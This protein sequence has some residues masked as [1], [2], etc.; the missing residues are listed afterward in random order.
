M[1]TEIK[2]LDALLGNESIQ[3]GSIIVIKGGPGSGKTTLGLQILNNNLKAYRENGGEEINAGFISLEV[4]FKKAIDYARS[5]Y[6]FY[7]LML[8]KE[9]FYYASKDDIKISIESIFEKSHPVDLSKPFKECLKKGNKNLTRGKINILFVDSLNILIDLI[10]TI[11]TNKATPNNQSITEFSFREIINLICGTAMSGLTNKSKPDTVYIF[12]VEYH[13]SLL[14]NKIFISES[15]ISDIEILLSIEPIKETTLKPKS[16]ISGV[17]YEIEVDKEGKKAYEYRSFLR[18][19]K[20]RYSKHHSRRCSYDI[21]SGRGIVFFDTY[22]GDGQISL[23]Y[24]NEK[25]REVWQEFFLDDI[26]HLYPSL[27][28]EDFK[29]KNI[30]QTLS[31]HRHIKYI[32]EK[33]DLSLTSLDNYWVTWYTDLWRKSTIRDIIESSYVFKRYLRTLKMEPLDLCLDLIIN[34]IHS[35]LTRPRVDI[36]NYTKLFSNFKD[37]AMKGLFID[38]APK[39]NFSLHFSNRTIGYKKYN[40]DKT[41]PEN[42]AIYCITGVT[43]IHFMGLGGGYKRISIEG[44]REINIIGN[45]RGMIIQ[46]ISINGKIL[47]TICTN[48]SHLQFKVENKQTLIFNIQNGITY[49]KV[50]EPDENGPFNEI[51]SE[52]AGK[53]IYAIID[54][55]IKTNKREYLPCFKDIIL[56]FISSTYRKKINDLFF[57]L[58]SEGNLKCVECHFLT[59]LLSFFMENNKNI[60]QNL[61]GIITEIFYDKS[62]ALNSKEKIFNALK[63]SKMRID[64]TTECKEET[65]QKEIIY[66]L[67]REL[68][69]DKYLNCRYEKLP[70]SLAEMQESLADLIANRTI[71]KKA[72]CRW[73]IRFDKLLESFKWEID[74]NDLEKQLQKDFFDLKV[75]DGGHFIDK[76]SN[77]F[78]LKDPVL[79][80]TL[81]RKQIKPV[82][83]DNQILF[84][85]NLAVYFFLH[86][87]HEQNAKNVLCA[88]KKSELRL[89]GERNSDIIDELKQYDFESN[90]PVHHQDFVF[91]MRNFDEFISVPYD[92]NISFVVYNKTTLDIF[93]QVLVHKLKSSNKGAQENET[94]NAA[95]LKY[96]DLVSEIFT[97]KRTVLDSIVENPPSIIDESRLK[98]NLRKIINRS[99]LFKHPFT[100]EEVIALNQ[101][102]KCKEFKELYQDYKNEKTNNNKNVPFNEDTVFE[103]SQ[104]QPAFLIETQTYDTYLSILL[105]FIW[106]SGGD[107]CSTPDY[108]L[109]TLRETDNLEKNEAKFRKDLLEALYLICL[110]FYS[111]TIPENSTLEPEMFMNRYSEN[112]IAPKNDLGNSKDPIKKPWLFARHWYSTFID[113][114]AAKSKDPSASKGANVEQRELLWK[115]IAHQLGIMPIPVSIDRYLKN[116]DHPMEVKHISCWGDWHFAILRGSENEALGV[117]LINKLMSSRNIADRAEKCAHVP[118]TEAFYSMYGKNRCINIPERTDGEKLPNITYNE[119][120]NT[121]FKHAKSRSQIFDFHHYMREI[122]A[123]LKYAEH[124]SI[125]DKAG[126]TT[127]PITE[128]PKYLLRD[129]DHKIIEAL[130]VMREFN[131]QGLNRF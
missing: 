126:S 56:K 91:S 51:N 94:E 29:R 84:R 78:E 26:P 17:G 37:D 88:Q 12:S 74:K 119:L 109:S 19:I 72:N 47:K 35:L 122:H 102:I 67:L 57:T 99:L 82:D 14:E 130:S 85:K 118:T 16:F 38:Y 59:N 18:V 44:S 113:L 114:L 60:K 71:L 40:E 7:E 28:Y 106:N 110:M 9:N 11:K 31:T 48:H 76:L 27:R 97:K 128:F 66:D 125:R 68:L 45:T 1:K 65:L 115:G 98:N 24:E 10:H 129:I 63:E 116:I 81:K 112:F 79:V 69:N 25:Q 103:W 107:I 52:I 53:S 105:E 83:F 58:S 127:E 22:P 90:R 49:K 95:Y 101:V 5:L 46:R 70:S 39:N 23:F 3:P 4:P 92:A 111:G 6:G 50:D 42:P 104:P 41:L 131:Y 55:E 54:G 80:K 121:L 20:S 32:P 108:I 93:Y 34:R 43:E 73:K 8:N 96:L 21:K 123:V 75:N 61:N 2:E 117:E 15:F 33:I 120:R 100:W 87:L 89:F 86:L 30:Q 13:P 77:I 36:T 62:D 124:I 64:R